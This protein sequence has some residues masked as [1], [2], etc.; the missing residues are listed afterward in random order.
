MAVITPSALVS[1][2]RGSVGDQTFSRNRYGP[3]VKQKLVQPASNTAAQIII[4]D[5][6][7]AGVAAWKLTTESTKKNWDAFVSKHLRSKNIS[8]QVRISAFNEFTGRYINR[9]I[10]EGVNTGFTA[11]PECLCYPVI[12]SV[13]QSFESLEVN[14]NALQTPSDVEFVIYATPPMDSTIRSIN[15]SSYKVLTHFTPGASTGAEDIFSALDA[16]YTITSANVGQRIGLCIKSVNADNYASAKPAYLDFILSAAVVAAPPI[17]EQSFV[18]NRPAS[19]STKVATFASAPTEDSLIILQI[20]LT[21]QPSI[22]NPTGFTT[23][24]TIDQGSARFRIC[25]KIAGPSEPS[26]YTFTLSAS[27]VGYVGGV[28]VTGVDTST[29]INDSDVNQGSGAIANPVGAADISC[30]D[31]SL[32]L[33][34]ILSSSG[35]MTFVSLTN[36]FT[37]VDAASNA[38]IQFAQRN[39]GSAS[40]VVNTVWDWSQT[41]NWASC[42]I[43]ISPV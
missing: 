1:E 22:T 38:P 5:A 43:A 20:M 39:Y 7:S 24:H 42:I 29:P 9:A 6:L 16:M 36:S 23:L 17:I 2:I 12:T 30:L 26:S 8:R 37:Q 11:I 3:Y 33:A 10:V 41:R 34:I 28:E 18:T 40:A 13:S 27:G 35:N 19:A 21:S 14:W 25:Y 31:N 32:A 15:K 4:R